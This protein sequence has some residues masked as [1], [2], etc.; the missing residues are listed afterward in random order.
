MSEM[1]IFLKNFQN[2]FFDRGDE[3]T[4]KDNSVQAFKFNRE[5]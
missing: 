1:L 4:V 5:F 3:L 2:E